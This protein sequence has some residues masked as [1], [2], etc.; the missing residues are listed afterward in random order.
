M[1][2]IKHLTVT[3]LFFLV[4]FTTSV[5]MAND[6]A[7]EPHGPVIELDAGSTLDVVEPSTEVESSTNTTSSSDV[8]ADVIQELRQLSQQARQSSQTGAGW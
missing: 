2:L 8:N 4:A 6:L 3:A 1:N 7:T 5:A